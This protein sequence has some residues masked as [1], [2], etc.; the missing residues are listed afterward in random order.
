M[1]TKS[2]VATICVSNDRNL[3][4]DLRTVVLIWRRTSKYAAR[5]HGARSLKRL[6]ASG[7]VQRGP[8]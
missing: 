7:A 6:P 2:R 8:D 1:K 3:R 4:H 5:K